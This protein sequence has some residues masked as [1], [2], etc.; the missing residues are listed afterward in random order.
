MGIPVS[1]FDNLSVEDR[2]YIL[3]YFLAKGQ[4]EAW[5]VQVQGD[6]ILKKNG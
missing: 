1:Q 5:E 3:A 6:E 2:A 4:M